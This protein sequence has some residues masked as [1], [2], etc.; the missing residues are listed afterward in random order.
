MRPLAA[1]EARRPPPVTPGILLFVSLFE[2]RIEV[3][4]D[5]GICRQVA[6]EAWQEVVARIRH[7]IATGRLADGLVAAIE[8]CGE[9]LARAAVDAQPGDEDE[10]ALPQHLEVLRARQG[11]G[12]GSL[13]PLARSAARRRPSRLSAG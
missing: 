3:M 11:G 9:L 7:G 12:C 5:T 8:R 1:R 13:G 10:P 4:A 2:R 6:P